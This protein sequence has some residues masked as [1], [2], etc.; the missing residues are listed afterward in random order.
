MGE[1]FLVDVTRR[2]GTRQGRLDMEEH[3][4][5]RWCRKK[6]LAGV[7]EVDMVSGA[8]LASESQ[9]AEQKL[10]LK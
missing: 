2:D 9:V 8:R 6:I 5:R 7:G 4:E 3:E 10:F 1:R